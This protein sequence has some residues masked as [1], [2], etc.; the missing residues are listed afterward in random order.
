MSLFFKK[1]LP[2][3]ILRLQLESGDRLKSPYIP[4]CPYTQG[5]KLQFERTTQNVLSFQKYPDIPQCSHS[6]GPKLKLESAAA[7]TCQWFNEMLVIYLFFW[8]FVISH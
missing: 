3:Q 7:L 4:Q 8:F 6:Q 5:L 2:L 1:S